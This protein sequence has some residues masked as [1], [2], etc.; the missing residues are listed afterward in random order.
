MLQTIILLILHHKYKNQYNSLKFVIIAVKVSKNTKLK[1]IYILKC[2]LIFRKK[3]NPVCY[4]MTN[5]TLVCNKDRC[6]L[7]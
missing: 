1:I 5:K 2:A 6:F 3:L 7:F 4:K